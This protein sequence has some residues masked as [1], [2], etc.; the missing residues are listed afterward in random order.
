MLRNLFEVEFGGIHKGSLP[1]PVTVLRS[2]FVELLKMGRP[3]LTCATVAFPVLAKGVIPTRIGRS[4]PPVP[5]RAA[6]WQ[7][8]YYRLSLQLRH[9]GCCI[10]NLVGGCARIGLP[11]LEILLFL[12]LPSSSHLLN[13]IRCANTRS[14][15]T[16]PIIS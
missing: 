4:P 15:R 6:S 3:D 13:M 12:G 14:T 5:F 7:Q 9:T 2:M 16:T 10:S 11:W 8:R 1:N